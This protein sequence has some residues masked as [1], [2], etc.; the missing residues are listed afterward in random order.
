MADRSFPSEPTIVSNH[1]SPPCNPSNNNNVSGTGGSLAGCTAATGNGGRLPQFGSAGTSQLWERIGGSK[2]PVDPDISPQSSDEYVVGGEYEIIPDMRFGLNYTHREMHRAIEDM[3]RDEANTYF[4]GN[5]GYGIASDF[6]K[7]VRNYDALN[8]VL[9]KTYSNTWLLQASYT[10]SRLY[11]NYA[12]LFRPETLQLDPNITSDFDLKSLLPN[13]MGPLPGDRTHQIKIFAAKD[14][15]IPAGQD[16]LLG[17]T[18]RSH[19]G[20]P[21]NALGAHAI[22]GPDEAYVLPRGTGGSLNQDLS[23]TQAR[24]PWVHSFDTRIGYSVRLSKDTS[25]QASMDIF[26]LFDFQAATNLD[27]AYTFS[28]VLP[29]APGG[30]APA[31]VKHSD[32]TPFNKSEVNPNYGKP[33]QYQDPRQWRFGA[34]LTF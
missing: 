15:L 18:F 32:G 8:V 21:L 20:S 25:L 23:V 26:N 1:A 34:K 33:T 19:S 13:Q 29:C 16:I 4:I 14:F 3:S 27:Q 6:P 24:S 9:T 7:A 5:P 28:A 12:G 17:L 2:E 10:L 30:V 22:Y 31:C 11:G